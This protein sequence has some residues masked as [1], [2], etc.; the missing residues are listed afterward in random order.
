MQGVRSINGE[1]QKKLILMFY[2]IEVGRRG[3]RWRCECAMESIVNVY[4]S[5]GK[6][7]RIDVSV[8][9]RENGA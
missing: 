9:E 3:M 2:V 7:A 6:R 8:S 5:Q 1:T 4:I